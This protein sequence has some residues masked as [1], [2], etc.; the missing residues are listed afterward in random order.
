MLPMSER[1]SP[2]TINR[3]GASATATLLI[4][5]AAGVRIDHNDLT[6]LLYAQGL[7]RRD[8]VAA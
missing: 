5:G 4:A 6:A 3:L 7:A 2:K 1:L 8:W